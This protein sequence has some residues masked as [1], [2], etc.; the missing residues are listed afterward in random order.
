VVVDWDNLE[1]A[2]PGREVARA[3]FD[4]FCDGPTADLD[5]MPLPC[6]SPTDRCPPVP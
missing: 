4:W 5:A 6:P 1:P 2:A 3:R